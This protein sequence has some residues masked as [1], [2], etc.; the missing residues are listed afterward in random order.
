MNAPALTISDDVLQNGFL[1]Q[2]I[3]LR[4]EQILA[5]AVELRLRARDFDPR[6]GDARVS[7]HPAGHVLG[8]AQI[9][10]EVGGY[11]V[12]VSGDYK[13]RRDPTCAAFEP[14]RLRMS[15]CSSALSQLSMPRITLPKMTEIAKGNF[16][17]AA[18][19][20]AMLIIG[21]LNRK[22][23][24]QAVPP[25]PPEPLV[26]AVPVMIDELA[27]PK[28]ID[29]VKV[30]AM[31]GLLRHVQADVR[32]RGPQGGAQQP[33]RIDD[34]TRNR[35]NQVTLDILNLKDPPPGRTPEGH[36]WMQRRAID[37]LA[38]M[39]TIS[40]DVNAA[41]TIEAMISNPDAPVSLRC[42]AA[43]LSPSTGIIDSHA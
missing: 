35:I 37:I 16:H 1:L 9:R 32:Q 26:E 28:Q 20:N 11:S 42:T 34:A 6:I 30:A 3:G 8:S 14:T 22:E 19:M 39:G 4:H 36:A 21:D 2:N 5:G 12:V 10:I 13:R 43:L 40:S 38:V 7:F 31:V 33:Q 15:R 29:A 18:R 27:D 17:P 25:Q 23:A 41:Q 24:V